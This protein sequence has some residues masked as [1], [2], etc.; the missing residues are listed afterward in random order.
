[1]ETGLAG[2]AT[3]G[4]PSAAGSPTEALAFAIPPPPDYVS[5]FGARSPLG[6][7]NGAGAYNPMERV[8]QAAMGAYVSPFPDRPSRTYAAPG[9]GSA[10]GPLS[11]SSSSSLAAA[12]TGGTGGSTVAGNVFLAQSERRGGGTNPFSG[13]PINAR[14]RA[15]R[16]PWS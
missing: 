2:A 9:M 8:T 7:R 12:A 14:P 6:A 1:M 3:V 16:R 13:R 15:V 10:Y 11:S 5:P 4:S